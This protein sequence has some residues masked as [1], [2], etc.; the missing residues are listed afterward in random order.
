MDNWFY[1]SS[2]RAVSLAL[3]DAFT[4]LKIAKTD[5]EGKVLGMVAVPLKYGLK[6]KEYLFKHD[7]KFNPQL[8]MMGMYS[9][10]MQYSQDRATQKLGRVYID[11]DRNV[12][13]NKVTELINPV[14]WD[15]SYTLEI[16]TKFVLEAE[17]ILEQILPFFNPFLMIS[18]PIPEI[19]FSYDCKVVLGSVS[20]EKQTELSEEEVRNIKW[21]I[22]LACHAYLFKPVTETKLITKIVNNYYDMNSDQPFRTQQII[23][24][25]VDPIKMYYLDHNFEDDLPDETH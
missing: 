22:E 12:E 1:Y 20:E 24:G 8:P 23:D 5:K 17:Q 9:T 21:T 13:V 19:G 16:A 7:K 11:L 15:I 6:T 4:G 3:T 18:V 10:Q 2:I 14:P 25:T